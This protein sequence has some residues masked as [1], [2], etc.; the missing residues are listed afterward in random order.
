[1]HAK[2]ITEASLKRR[3]FVFSHSGRIE[4]LLD[5]HAKL[6]RKCHPLHVSVVDRRFM[7]RG[8]AILL[9]T[10]TLDDYHLD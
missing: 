4:H 10:M 2:P 6:C 9:E 1:M 8:G 7:V 5:T 3:C